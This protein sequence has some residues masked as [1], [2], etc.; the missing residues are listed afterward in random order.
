MSHIDALRERLYQLSDLDHAA[1][2]ASWDQQTMMPARGGAARAESLATL[3]RIRHE[4]FVAG[5][6]GRLLDAAA[7]QLDGAGDAA[8]PDSDDAR[9]VWLTRRDYD[10]A[11]R[12]PSALAA[13]LARAASVGHEAWAA[14]RAASDFRAFA[15]Y[16]SHNLELTRRYV[17]CHLD[18]PD[19]SCAYDVLL[20]DYEP[21]MPTAQ[22]AA[23]FEELRTDLVALIAAVAAAP[24]VSETPLHARFA[25]DGQRRLVAEVV[26]MMGF[27]A[28]AWRM[29]DTVHPFAL[30]IGSGDVRITNRWD[31]GY[32]PMGLYGSMHECGHGL[33]E[34][35]LAPSLM[36][37]P[38]GSGESLGMHESQSRL[39]ENMVGRGRAFC[40]VLAPRIA[41]LAQGE[42]SDLDADRLF[43]AVNRVKPDFIRVEADEATYGLHIVLRF[44]LEQALV[45]GRLAVSE[46]P[47]AWNDRMRSD[48]GVQVTDDAHGVLQDVHW[49]GASFGYFPTYALG[50]LIAGQLWARVREDIPELE[51]Q[52]ADGD[53]APLREW[54]RD[55]IHRH[56][57]K[58]TTAEL[59]QSATGAP[60]AAA[61]YTAYLRE[62]LS[63]VYGVDLGPRRAGGNGA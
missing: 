62:K 30:R 2:L 41:A 24:P 29:D 18:D 49:S 20:D 21:R 40:T 57:S 10:K 8:D 4:M 28:D 50:N 46:L 42:L 27:T 45:D 61:P 55:R 23:L 56:G 51:A 25:I 33:Y 31:E 38:L 16:L 34:A 35:G 3:A 44:E 13:E 12:V 47:E 19:F 1:S 11:R 14:A 43:T 22:V 32:W 52:L 6:T 9:L 58:F 36:R 37:T 5:E 54:L 17:E 53:L 60:I 59:L 48:L 7:A 15:P 63:R 26:G 39:W